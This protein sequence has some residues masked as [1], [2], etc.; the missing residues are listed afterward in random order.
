MIGHILVVT[1]VQRIK[2][3]TVKN[4]SSVEKSHIR[5]RFKQKYTVGNK[6]KG[7]ISKRIF[8]EEKARQVSRKRNIS[9]ALIRT[10]TR[11]EN[12]RFSKNWACFV[13]FKHFF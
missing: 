7:R 9:Y 6:A 8:Q 2:K 12:V 1:T 13:F 5:V 4:I 11:V 10:R 3:S